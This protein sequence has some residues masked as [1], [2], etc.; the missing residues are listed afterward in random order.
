VIDKVNDLLLY[1]NSGDCAVI[2]LL[3]LS[4]TFDTVDHSILLSR[5]ESNFGLTGKALSW[6]RSYLSGRRQSVRINDVTSEP[7]PLMYGVPQ[8]SVLGPVLFILYTTPLFGVMNHYG[9]SFHFFVDD[10]QAYTRFST[11]DDGSLQGTAFQR[12]A[13]CVAGAGS[14]M[15]QNKLQNNV[16]KLDAVSADGTKHPPAT[17]SLA[18]GA[19]VIIPFPCVKNLG[20]VIDSHLSL[21]AQIRSVCKKAF[22]QIRRISR[23]RKFLDLTN[24]K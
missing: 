19:N 21:E 15:Q 1:V 18:I 17:L 6:L 3:D 4:A 2:T 22:Y 7:T 5:L 16:G 11:K 10:T 9:V 8:G 24:L 14:W 23:I 20:V 12:M 13:D